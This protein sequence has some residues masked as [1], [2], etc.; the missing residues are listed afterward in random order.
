MKLLISTLCLLIPLPFIPTLTPP[1]APSPPWHWN[2]TLYEATANQI[3]G[4]CLCETLFS[5]KGG[6]EDRNNILLIPPWPSFPTP[7]VSKLF[8][9]IIYLWLG[10][11]WTPSFRYSTIICS[12]CQTQKIVLHASFKEIVVDA[13]R[14]V[15]FNCIFIRF[16]RKFY[17]IFLVNPLKQLPMP[18]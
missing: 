6:K 4:G 2:H 9:L 11:R 3:L 14:E 17:N 13:D 10:W 15:W 7:H 12:K 5:T 8:D 1:K 18:P 16:H